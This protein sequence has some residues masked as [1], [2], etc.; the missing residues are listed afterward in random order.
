MGSK[1]L[2]FN[3]RIRNIPQK[4][5]SQE[6]MTHLRAFTKFEVTGAE[7]TGI[8]AYPY[9]YLPVMFIKDMKQGN[10]SAEGIVIPKG[11]IVSLITNQTS[12]VPSGMI[13]SPTASGTIPQFIDVNTG[14]LVLTPI[15]DSYFGYEESIASLLV[16]CNGGNTSAIPYSVLD[17]TI[18]LWNASTDSD[19]VL[20]P[21]IPH[22][23]AVEDMY[24]DIRGAYLNYQTKDAYS[25]IREGRVDIPFCDTALLSSILGG[26][27][28]TDADVAAGTNSPYAAT[29]RTWTFL[30]FDSTTNEGR[31]GNLLKS[32]LYGNW[33]VQSN[34]VTANKTAQTVGRIETTDCRFPKEISA[35]IQ[36][37]Q[38]TALLGVNT[39]GV[40]TD[41]YLFVQAVLGNLGLDNDAQHILDA[42]QEGIF[43][44]ARVQIS[45]GY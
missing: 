1:R 10:V 26:T 8:R 35:T 9:K 19:L 38:G 39:A 27:F 15:D 29:W 20:S 22:G 17:D 11:R 18:G 41:L 36:N 42:I 7:Y 40:P 31:S 5:L 32:D 45:V 13:P 34:S 43:G 44:F 16:L 23:V 4:T 25:A 33:L 6:N 12:I 30:H 37:Y 3:D 14:N 21:N 24:Q 2:N 28:G